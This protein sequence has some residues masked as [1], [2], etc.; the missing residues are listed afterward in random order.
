MRRFFWFYAS[1]R[2]RWQNT[3]FRWTKEGIWV[4]VGRWVYV[5]RFRPNG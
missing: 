4:K 3:R 2:N 5:W 1:D